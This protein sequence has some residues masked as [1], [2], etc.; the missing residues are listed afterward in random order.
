MMTVLVTEA[1]ACGRPVVAKDAGDVRYL[2]NDGEIGFL[3]VIFLTLSN[4]VRYNT[5]S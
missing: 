1:I 2:V 5:L 3:F 4:R